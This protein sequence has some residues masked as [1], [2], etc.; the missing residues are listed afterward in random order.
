MSQPSTNEGTPS[1][2]TIMNEGSESTIMK[3]AF[4]DMDGISKTASPQGIVVH[5]YTLHISDIGQQL[6]I[7]SSISAWDADRPD[8]VDMLG[9]H[10]FPP[11]MP[12]EFHE[13]S[14]EVMLARL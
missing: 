7:V 14:D 4:K 9:W 3:D 13:G 8:I 2:D 11:H 1:R 6:N 5:K 12:K 10:Q